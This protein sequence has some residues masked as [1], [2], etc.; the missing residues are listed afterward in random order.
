MNAED[1]AC[2]EKRRTTSLLKDRQD[3]KIVKMFSFEFA[4]MTAPI[5]NMDDGS[6]PGI[7]P[8]IQGDTSPAGIG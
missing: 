1:S 7:A 2:S 3:K 4:A 5:A 6:H 8:A